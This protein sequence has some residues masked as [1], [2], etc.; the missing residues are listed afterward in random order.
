MGKRIAVYSPLA[1]EAKAFQRRQPLV[2]LIGKVI[3]FIDNGKPN[4]NYLV[5][6]L[7]DLLM[8]KYGAAAVIK[9]RKR[10]PSVPAPQ[11]MMS[12]IV[13]HCDAVVTGS[14]D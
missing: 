13:A 1:A 14:G 8:R 2:S 9:R 6:D 11:Q 4:F 7:A 3:G 12:E 5:D 10:G